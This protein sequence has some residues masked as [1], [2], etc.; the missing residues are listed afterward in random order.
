MKGQ[1]L[2]GLIVVVTI[3]PLLALEEIVESETNFAVQLTGD[4]FNEAI[5]KNNHFI[6]FYAPW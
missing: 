2:C 6:K 5:S 3:L 4:D 1:S